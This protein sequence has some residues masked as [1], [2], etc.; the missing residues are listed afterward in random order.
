MTAVTLLVTLPLQRTRHRLWVSWSDLRMTFKYRLLLT[1]V[2][3]STITENFFLAKKSSDSFSLVFSFMFLM[4]SLTTFPTVTCDLWYIILMAMH[5]AS[6]NSS[7]LT[8]WQ[9]VEDNLTCEPL[10]TTSVLCSTETGNG[11]LHNHGLLLHNLLTVAGIVLLVI[12]VRVQPRN[13]VTM[14][15]MELHGRGAAILRNAYKMVFFALPF[16][17]T[18][19]IS[20]LRI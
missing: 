4:W 10:L 19:T 12:L 20:S 7:Q 14:K 9:Y 6:W 8:K 3:L 1:L 15:Q 13:S 16:L 11:R 18:V 17:N 2:Y 5:T